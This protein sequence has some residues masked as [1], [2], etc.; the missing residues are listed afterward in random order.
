M[1]LPNS[2]S[3]SVSFACDVAE[4]LRGN[5]HELSKWPGAMAFCSTLAAE[6]ANVKQCLDELEGTPT[7]PSTDRRVLK[8]LDNLDR[9]CRVCLTIGL[10][11]KR[12]IPREAGKAAISSRWPLRPSLTRHL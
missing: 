5:A 9:L 10:I 7:E 8:L 1:R 6:L 3:S 2:P 4:R 11:G 12:T